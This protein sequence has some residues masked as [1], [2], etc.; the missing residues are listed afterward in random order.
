MKTLGL[1]ILAKDDLEMLQVTLP[2]VLPHVDQCV[3]LNNRSTDGSHEWLSQQPGVE[4]FNDPRDVLDVGYD[5]LTNEA[6]SHM[7][8][9]W[10]LR[11]DA[12]EIIE[13]GGYE[14]IREFIET[15]TDVGTFTNK[16][17]QLEPRPEIADWRNAVEWRGYWAVE[18]HRLYPRGLFK[19]V[20]A[21]HEGLA[22]TGAVNKRVKTGIGMHHFSYWRNKDPHEKQSVYD[23]LTNPSLPAISPKLVSTPEIQQAFINAAVSAK[24]DNFCEIGAYEASASIKMTELLPECNVVAFEANP[25]NYEQFKDVPTR[26]EHMA[27]SNRAGEVPFFFR[28]GVDPNVGNNSLLKRSNTEGHTETMVPCDTL[29]SLVWESDQNYALWIDVEGHA[30]EVL[31][32]AHRVLQQTLYILVELEMIRYW[33]AQSLDTRVF[34]FLKDRG[35]EPVAY[36]SEYVYQYNVMFRNTALTEPYAI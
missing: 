1:F 7:K 2:E 3:V 14:K 20:N 27:V 18:S 26:Y 24:V 17:Y 34:Q 9:D 21:L 30:Y 29:D 31:E 35:F 8:T 6:A 28:P 23:A 22:P 10:I 32:G 19:W 4:V 12:D 15:G 16:T 25:L 33:E 5:V 13:D 36:D 11:L